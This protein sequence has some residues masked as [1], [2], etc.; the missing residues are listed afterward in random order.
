MTNWYE[1]RDE[2]ESGQIF[3]DE[4]DKR[5]MLDRP[6][7]GDATQWYVATWWNESWAYVDAIIEPGD[8]KELI[9]E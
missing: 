3:L 9:T 1:R 7:P 8:L 5:V 4:N 2:L 6:V